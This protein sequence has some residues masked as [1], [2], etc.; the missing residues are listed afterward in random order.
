[1][2]TQ[3]GSRDEISDLEATILIVDDE[4]DL[5]DLFGVW[6]SER[7]TVHTVYSGHDA[8]ELLDNTIDVVLLDRSMPG[9]SGDAVL[10]EIR[11]RELNCRVALVTAHDPDFDV[12]RL[13]FDE[14]VTKPV[15]KDA[16]YD[17]VETL[18][19]RKQYDTLLQSYYQLASK[20]ATLEHYLGNDAA[21]H[22]AY[23]ALQTEIEAL[24]GD[25]ADLQVG[26]DDTDFMSQLIRLDQPADTT[27]LPNAPNGATE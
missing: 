17:V 22:P 18:L 14:Y 24:D 19:T 5:A 10:T 20:L 12:I 9:L 2:G 15:P 11:A 13:G 3:N 4:Q 27:N 8:L 16:L 23:Q 26:F 6:L 1:M 25:I 7:Y 21:S